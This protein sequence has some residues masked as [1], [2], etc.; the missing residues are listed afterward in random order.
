MTN[1]L[2]G[3]AVYAVDTGALALP[4]HTAPRMERAFV[5]VGCAVEPRELE[6]EQDLIVPNRFS[7]DRAGLPAPGA[8]HDAVGKTLGQRSILD[9]LAGFGAK[10]RQFGHSHCRLAF[11]LLYQPPLGVPDL[12][13]SVMQ[14]NR[15]PVTRGDSHRHPLIRRD[16]LSATVTGAPDAV[17]ITDFD[18]RVSWKTA[19]LNSMSDELTTDIGVHGTNDQD[20]M[21]AVPH[22]I[23]RSPQ[24]W[25]ASGRSSAGRIRQL[26]VRTRAFA[27]SESAS[28][29]S[30]IYGRG[31]RTSASR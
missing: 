31:A 16:E 19:A 2:H 22:E 9:R 1:V 24:P 26:V 27:S 21:A 7:A 11:A 8:A 4:G 28:L 3:R 29:P 17:A 25:R 14:S 15:S 6:L 13:A 12:K 20:V 30:L 18:Q 23:T 5:H 10:S